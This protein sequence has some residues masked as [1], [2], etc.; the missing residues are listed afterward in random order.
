MKLAYRHLPLVVTA[1]LAAA[2]LFHGPIAQPAGYHDFADQKIVFGIPHFADV[3]S[4][5]GFAVVAVWGWIKLAPARR[6]PDIQSGWAGYR[7]FLIGLFLTALGSSW[8]HLAPDNASLVWDRLPIA[9]ACGGLLAGVWG[10]VRQQESRGLVAGL[11]LIAVASVGWWYF[12]DLSGNGDLRPYLLLQGLPILLIPLWQWIYNTPGPD[13]LAFGAALALYVIAKF[14]ELN[15]HE[16]AAALGGLTG[17]TL[18]HLLATAAAGL[19]VAR[20]VRRIH[21]PRT[22]QQLV[23]L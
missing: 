4:N 12:T 18:K 19:I 7:L 21:A 3:I 15:D 1:L 8:Y 2:A 10:D 23:R 6:H 17:H 16:I 9:L 5:L 11:A 20:L 13:R 22:T 14:A